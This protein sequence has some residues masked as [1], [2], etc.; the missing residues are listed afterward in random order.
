[1]LD[2]ETAIFKHLIPDGGA[3]PSISLVSLK[4]LQVLIFWP[5]R[6][7]PCRTYAP[8]QQQCITSS[9]PSP[10]SFSYEKTGQGSS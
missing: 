1:M 5:L 8:Q 3:L 2:L 4:L 9:S 10:F 7:G 6:L